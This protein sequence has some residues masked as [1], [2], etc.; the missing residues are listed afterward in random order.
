MLRPRLLRAALP[1]SAYLALAVGLFANAWRAPF[2]TIV[3]Y[4]GDAFQSIWFLR[5]PGFALTH[6]L[7]PLLST[8]V[9]HPHGANLMWNTAIPL[10]GVVLTPLTLT[11]GPVFV[12]NLV[13]TLAL[14]L[15]A[16]TA[17]LAIHRYVTTALAAWLGGLAY[18]FSPYMMAQS[19]GHPHLTIAFVPPLILLALDSLVIRQNRPALFIGIAAGALAALQLWIGEEL[20][21]SSGLVAILGLFILMEL[22][23]D[24]VR[25]QSRYALRAL[26]IAS[27][28]FTVLAAFPLAVQFFGPQ[29]LLRSLQPHNLYATDVLGFFVPTDMQQVAPEPAVGI[30]RHFTGNLSEWN[31]YLSLPLIGLL[32]FTAIRFWPLKVVRFAASL[33]LLIAGLSLGFTLRFA[34]SLT[35]VASVVVALPLPAFR[36]VLPA[37]TMVLAL[38]VVPIA[39]ITVPVI[40]NLLPSRLMLYADLM[41]GFLLATFAQSALHWPAVRARG[42]AV[43]A[44]GLTA[45][46]LIPRLP[47]PS[48]SAAT[49]SFF[50]SS[51]VRQI[52]EGAVVLVAPFARIGSGDAM[53][54]QAMAGDRFQMPEGGVIADGN[55]YPADPPPSTS[56]NVLRGIETGTLPALTLTEPLRQSLLNDLNRWHVRMVI[57]GPMAHQELV[58][59]LYSSVLGATPSWQG[60]VYTWTLPDG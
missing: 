60:G 15:S 12:Y 26:A 35:A 22:N 36:R 58:L 19:L 34:G 43:C 21:A 30:S 54:W 3:G 13:M 18:G 27:A 39:L 40:D 24:R 11:V 25:A 49:P 56:L 37:R 51:S 48:S 44:I 59:A 45:I 55:P 16:W 2:A 7:N 28:T 52:P 57:V 5:W 38:M 33:G 47:Y 23:P 4:P 1:L 31:G 14:A 42:V 29:P 32:V 20:L 50:T 8:Y 10:V 6:G 46:A 9:N 17:Y 53:L 41:A